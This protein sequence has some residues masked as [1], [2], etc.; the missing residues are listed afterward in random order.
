MLVLC[1]ATLDTPVERLSG[2]DYLLHRTHVF[3][4][5]KQPVPVLYHN[6][7][8][9]SAHQYFSSQTYHY[10]QATDSKA[11]A[12]E[13]NQTIRQRMA[14]LDQEQ[15]GT[16]SILAAKDEEIVIIKG[17]HPN[18]FRLAAIAHN[19]LQLR[20]SVLITRQTPQPSV[21][22]KLDKQEAEFEAIKQQADE[23]EHQIQELMKAAD[24]TKSVSVWT[25][26]T[27]KLQL[28]HLETELLTQVTGTLMAICLSAFLLCSVRSI[29]WLIGSIHLLLHW[30]S[31]CQP[32]H[33]P[34]RL[35][36]L[37]NT[38]TFAV[39]QPREH[40]KLDIR[41]LG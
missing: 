23:R 28:H 13:S 6:T 33:P 1:T 39:Y 11:K 25:S 32:C 41:Q 29:C 24:E 7:R 20:V 30:V 17:A 21:S 12:T 9:T 18:S 14:T 22:D 16:E 27:T 8:N 10:A 38:S 5:Y 35:L 2:Q 34:Q 40:S 26:K 3:H 19:T 31:I 36:G 4:R 15:D 37:C